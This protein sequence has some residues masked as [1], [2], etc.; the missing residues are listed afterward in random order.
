MTHRERVID[1]I[2][3]KES[4][5]VPIDLW[6]SDS[7]LVNDFYFKIIDYLNLEPLKNKVRPGKS[8]EYVDYRISDHIDSDFRHIVIGKPENFTSYKDKE[9][10]IYDEWG[11]G[12]KL[13]GMY[14]FI[15]HHPLQDGDLSDI[16]NYKGPMI[17]DPGRIKGLK[18]QAENWFKNTD[19][20]ITTTGPISGFIMEFYQYLCGTENFFTDLYLNVKFA[21]RLID[22]LSEIIAD[23]YMFFIEPIAPYIT[24]I[25]FESDFGMQDRPFMSRELFRKFLKKPMGMIF[26]RVKKIAPDAKIFLHSCGSIRELIPDLIDIGVNVL[27]GLQPLASGMNSLELKKEFGRDLVFHGG[28]DMQKALC[29]SIDDTILE[30]KK[31]IS[32]YGPGGGY[33]CGPSNHFQIDVPID[34]FLAMYKTAIDFGVYP[35]SPYNT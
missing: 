34:N 25:E 21:E 23:L 10:T 15:S 30:T 27:S 22:K 28:V 31:R 19:Y 33:I 17:R 2:N 29:G 26:S 12:Y 32:D 7:R 18:D 5:R 20:C 14:P 3:H 9:G 11:I 16:D 4:D 8:A 6:G 1:A 35:L 24:W 13:K